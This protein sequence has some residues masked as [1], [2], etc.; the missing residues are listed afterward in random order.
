[1]KKLLYLFLTVFI[2]GCSGEDNNNDDDNNNQSSCPIYLD[3]NGVTIKACEDANVGDMGVIDGVTYTV[4]DEAML[5]AMVANEEDLTKVV[6]TKVT[7]MSNMFFLGVVNGVIISNDFNQP[8]GSWD[9]S[10]VTN[11]ANLFW[12]NYNFDQPLGSW[13]VSNVTDMRGMFDYATSFNHPI[14]NW[15]I[16]NVALIEGMFRGAS[17]FNQPISNWDVSKIQKI[18]IMFYGAFAYNQDLSSWSVNGVTDCT[19]FSEGASSWT[20]PKPN[21]T[22]CDPN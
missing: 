2:V 1:M 11:M 18:A 13:D 9:V 17:T 6:T 7:D 4:V 20:L 19:D 22:N 3:S 8:I 16:S 21:F 5:R 10:N 12:H 15:N 14:G